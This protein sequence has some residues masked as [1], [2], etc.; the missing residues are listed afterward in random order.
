MKK[1]WK[2]LV[3]WMRRTKL[4]VQHYLIKKLGGY[5][6]QYQRTQHVFILPKQSLQIQRLVMERRIAY[7]VAASLG[8]ER[9]V[10]YVK[11]S[12]HQIAYEMAEALTKGGIIFESSQEVIRNEMILRGTCYLISA[13]EAAKTLHRLMPAVQPYFDTDQSGQLYDVRVIGGS[14]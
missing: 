7:P 5:T 14:I 10:D 6:E 8:N 2:R 1:Q 3:R 11:F 9:M 13:E 4:R 12:Q